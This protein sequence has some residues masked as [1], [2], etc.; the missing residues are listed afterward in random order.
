MLYCTIAAIQ[1]KSPALASFDIR[2]TTAQT[3]RRTSVQA[4][5]SPFFNAPPGSPLPHFNWQYPAACR[6]GVCAC[7]AATQAA[8]TASMPF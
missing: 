4:N 1:F 6:Q 7:H 5:D 2:I 8:V 3:A